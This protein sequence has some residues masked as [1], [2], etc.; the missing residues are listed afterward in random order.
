MFWG[1]TLHCAAGTCLSGRDLTAVRGNVQPFQHKM[2]PS[3][4]DNTSFFRC[5][6][7]YESSVKYAKFTK[8]HF[9]YFTLLLTSHVIKHPVITYSG[10]HTLCCVLWFWWFC[11]RAKAGAVH[12]ELRHCSASMNTEDFKAFP[13]SFRRSKVRRPPWL[14]GSKW[15]STP[16]AAMMEACSDSPRAKR[17]SCNNLLHKIFLYG[18]KEGVGNI[19]FFKPIQLLTEG[20]WPD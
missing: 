2:L 18:L 13:K 15:A 9:R 17:S 5:S 11:Y 12:S 7:N 20:D 8:G 14:G 16:T 4:V 3:C 1:R 19:Y 6:Q 10:T